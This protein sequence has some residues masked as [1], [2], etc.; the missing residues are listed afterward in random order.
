M[1]IAIPMLS[2]PQFERAVERIVR[3]LT[4]LDPWLAPKE[5]AAYARVSKDHVLRALRAD[6]IEHVGE[7]RLIRARQSAVDRWL[8]SKGKKEE[9]A[10]A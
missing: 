10:N 1:D 5:I 7:G 8:A 3:R 2:D 4:T 9:G 6:A